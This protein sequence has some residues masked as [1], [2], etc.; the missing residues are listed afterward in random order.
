MD[1]SAPGQP[2]QA[3]SKGSTPD[4]AGTKGTDQVKVP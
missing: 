2:G 4:A 3:V 1:G